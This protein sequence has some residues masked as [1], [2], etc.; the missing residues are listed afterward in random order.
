MP[1]AET[2]VVGNV[3]AVAGFIAAFDVAWSVHVPS[4]SSSG[5][6]QWPEI[7]ELLELRVLP[8]S[9]GVTRIRRQDFR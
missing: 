1:T 7:L 3:L 8:V 2:L 9:R 5:R 4:V 6:G